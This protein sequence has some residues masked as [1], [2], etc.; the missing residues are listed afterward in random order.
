M[1]GNR[2]LIW[3]VTV[4]LL[5]HGAFLG[6][7]IS[8]GGQGLVLP[9]RP[10]P[11][12]I[13]LVK[14]KAHEDPPPRKKPVPQI[15]PRGVGHRVSVIKKTFTT[16]R[17]RST[18]V[19]EEKPTPVSREKAIAPPKQEKVMVPAREPSIPVPR[20]KISAK[21]PRPEEGVKKEPYLLARS[22]PSGKNLVGKEVPEARLIPKKRNRPITLARPRYD[23]NPKPPYPRAARRRGYEGVVLLKVEILPNGRVGEIQVKRSSGHSMLDRSALKTVRKWRFIPAKRAGEPI[24]IWAEVPIKFDLK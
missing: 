16:V 23:R 4:S 6:L 12:E 24:R 15:Q 13:S 20:G 2:N 8:P 21:A 11:L 17:K 9:R 14:V 1:N 18:A 22:T 19:V 5:I 3:G 10:T 7:A